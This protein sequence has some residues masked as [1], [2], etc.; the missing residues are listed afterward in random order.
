MSGARS[1][2]DEP[3]V[4]AIGPWRLTAFEACLAAIGTVTLLRIAV[5]LAAPSDLY[6]DEAQYWSWSRDF[7]FGY[8][9]KPPVIA[10]LIAA[11]TGLFGEHEWAVRLASPLVHAGTS[12]LVYAIGARLYDARIGLWSAIVY[13]SLPAVSFS[14]GLISTDVPLLFFWALALYA[15]IRL[16]TSYSFADG[17]LLGLALGGGLLSKYAMLYFPLGV[18]LAFA[19]N[20]KALDRRLVLPGLLALGLGLLVFAPNIAWNAAHKFSTVSHTAANANWHGNLFNP[21]ELLGFLGDQLGVF[22]PVLFGVLVFGL[23]QVL[24]GRLAGAERERAGD[25]LLLSFALPVLALA[26]SQAFISRANANWAAAAYV[27][28]TVLVTV[29]MLRPAVW[30]ALFP[31]SLA[32]HL[33]AMAVLYVL[34]LAPGL[35]D[36]LGRA[37]D[38]KRVRGWAALGALVERAAIAEATDMPLTAV[39]TDDRLTHAEILFYARRLPAPVVI[40]DANGVPENHYELFAPFT[41]ALGAH[42]LYVTAKERP[43]T[44][45]LTHFGSSHLIAR[46]VIPLG[47]GKERVVHL[48]ALDRYE[49]R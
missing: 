2:R 7:A 31:A 3:S 28:A 26:L 11:T 45:I 47:P 24:R 38:F 46:E 39:L 22:G 33:A 48:F 20:P 41:P 30:R 8:F 29:W 10:W 34:L 18:A 40:W 35:A 27:S 5:L 32:L 21:G 37:N 43:S 12:L 44:A 6:P 19:L 17:A 1:A 13:A 25:L 15:F 14:S 16:L 42:V 23:V 9:S 36:A 49:E 4:I